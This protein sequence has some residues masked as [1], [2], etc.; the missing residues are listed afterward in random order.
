MPVA[1]EPFVHCGGLH[2]GLDAAKAIGLGADLTGFAPGLTIAKNE[3]YNRV[4]AIRGVGFEAPQN[5]SAQPSV[6]YHVD[7]IFISNPIA[8]NADF[9]D[10]A[11]AR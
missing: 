9:L 2:H 10:V 11:R 6:S 8:L 3:G 1:V 5:D 4:V 7:G